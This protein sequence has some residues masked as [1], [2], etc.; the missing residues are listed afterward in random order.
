MENEAECLATELQQAK[1]S[2]L[3]PSLL[4]DVNKPL[5]LW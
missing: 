1:E 5:K 2:G 4:E 3:D